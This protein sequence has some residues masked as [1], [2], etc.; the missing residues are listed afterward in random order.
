[1]PETADI[2]L[3]LEGSSDL[4]VVRGLAERALL[5]ATTDFVPDFFTWR[6][7]ELHQPYLP[8]Q[9]V[10]A[11]LQQR[12][13]TRLY[14]KFNGL[15][16][17]PYA[18]RTR[19]ALLLA[20]YAN[21]LAVV[22]VCDADNQPERLLGLQQARDSHFADHYPVVVAVA[23][24]CREAWLVCSFAPQNDVEKNLL[25]TLH[26]ELSF[27]PCLQ[28]ERLNTQAVHVRNAKSVLN[29]LTNGSLEREQQI[30]ELAIFSHLLAHGQNCGLTAFLEE[31]KSRLAPLLGIRV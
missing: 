26:Q 4:R 13:M 30:L 25:E 1:M 12:R 21:P 10:D 27:H 5:E 18:F 23:N 31:V 15:E 3:I 9:N 16:G 29:R 24:P 14:G 2:V 19:H 11:E 8:W 6:G 7:L 22:L 20:H 17:S 28:P